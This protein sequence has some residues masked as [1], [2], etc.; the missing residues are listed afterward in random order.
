MILTKQNKFTVK[1]QAFTKSSKLASSGVKENVFQQHVGIVVERFILNNNYFIF[2]LFYYTHDVV[3][4]Y[5]IKV[6]CCN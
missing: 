5:A 4:G 2:I 6:L 3:G 1:S